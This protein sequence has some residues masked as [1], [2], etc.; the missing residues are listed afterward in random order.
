MERGTRLGPYEILELLGAGGMS[1]RAWLKGRRPS[2]ESAAGVGLDI[3]DF[4]LA[5][6]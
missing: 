2:V 6:L 5:K 3:L 1:L 4:G